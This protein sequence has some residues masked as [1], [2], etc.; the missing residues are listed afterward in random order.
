MGGGREL[1]SHYTRIPHCVLCGEKFVGSSHFRSIVFHENYSE[2]V[3]TRSMN[4]RGDQAIELP[5]LGITMH[6]G[7]RRTSRNAISAHSICWRALEERP[8]LWML[9]NLHLAMTPLFWTRLPQNIYKSYTTFSKA[10]RY[11]SA[12]DHDVDRE[13]NSFRDLITR[14]ASL[15]LELSAIIWDMIPPSAVRCLLSLCAKKDD[16]VDQP[17]AAGGKAIDLC[18]GNLVVYSATVLDGSYICG[19]RQGDTLYGHESN[20]YV[21]VAIPRAIAALTLLYGTYGLREISFRTEKQPY[22]AGEIGL[23]RGG[24]AYLSIIY[25]SNEQPLSLYIE[26][27]ALKISN[28]RSKGDHSFGQNF[29]WTSSLFGTQLYPLSPRSF[30]DWPRHTDFAIHSQRFM[31]FIPLLREGLC[32]YGL[33]AFCSTKGFV[34]LGVHFHSDSRS[35]KTYWYGIQEGCPV[36][37]QFADT[38]AINTISIFRHKN[39]P[40]SQPYLMGTTSMKR[41]FVLGPSMLS[42]DIDMKDLFCANNGDMLG[43]YYDVSPG[44]TSFTSMGIAYRQRDSLEKVSDYLVPQWPF[45]TDFLYL[46]N[47][48]PCG[49]F[50]SQAPLKNIRAVQACYQGSRC[51]GMLLTYND[52]TTYTLGQWYESTHTPFDTKVVFFKRDR[53]LRFYFKQ[54]GENL[55]LSRVESLRGASAQE[56]NIVDAV[57]GTN[58]TWLFSEFCDII[59]PL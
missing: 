16:W 31:S 54:H 20:R 23:T 36:H 26:W 4:F 10:N 14:V 37:F 21:R 3:L 51:K 12:K 30:Y 56:S 46:L 55:I 45:H 22:S 1:H 39:D 43:L 17:V 9:Q 48:S 8:S 24:S 32:L 27:D 57:Y 18:E 28:I 7:T 2:P 11:L 41:T 52:D 19:F 40:L 5:T 15:P 53:Y 25:P 44:I 35:S 33:T 49:G 38:E 6:K 47:T 29:L 58:I 34:G 50:I 59:L 13:S 42:S